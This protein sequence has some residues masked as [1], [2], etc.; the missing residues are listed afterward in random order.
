[1]ASALQCR[2]V[3]PFVAASSTH[4]HS[5]R[6]LAVQASQRNEETMQQRAAKLLLSLGAAA[7][8]ALSGP[9]FADNSNVRLPPL[10]N[11]PNRCERGFTGNTIGQANAVSNTALDLRFCDFKGA[12]LSGKTLSGAFMNETDF[13]GANMR[14][15]VLSKAY[16]YKSNLSGADMTNAV[17]DRVVLDGAN[18][19]G[20][21]FVNAVITGTTFKGANLAG[22]DFEDA[23]IG[24]EDAKRLCANPTLLGDS[25]DQVGCYQAR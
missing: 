21:K 23:L 8:L 4:R 1:M 20:A 13:S 7:T 5:R 6:C 17:I 2:A 16:A 9:A 25:R 18:L 15:T 10:D 14:E 24:S 12:N 3:S 19:E 22:A 11:D